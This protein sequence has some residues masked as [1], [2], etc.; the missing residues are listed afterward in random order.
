M[1]KFIIA[2][3]IIT[4]LAACTTK[5]E[6]SL[7]DLSDE[8]L[9]M[10]WLNVIEAVES[11][12][13]LMFLNNV[14]F[15]GSNDGRTKDEILNSWMNEDHAGDFSKEVYKLEKETERDHYYTPI[16][17]APD[18]SGFAIFLSGDVKWVKDRWRIDG[19][20]LTSL[21]KK[22]PTSKREGVPVPV[23]VGDEFRLGVA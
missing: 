18:E 13:K 5:E 17:L 12:D 10:L 15:H 21:R 22:S 8:E 1:K 23:K 14:Y 11:K 2:F 4:L 9:K 16:T 19:H 6:E 20:S 3:F 7:K